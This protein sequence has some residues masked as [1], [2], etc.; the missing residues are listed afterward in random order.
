MEDRVDKLHADF[1]NDSTRCVEL[2]E[3][4]KLLESEV[5]Q[6]TTL[7]NTTGLKVCTTSWC[8]HTCV[9]NK[10][11]TMRMLTKWILLHILHAFLREL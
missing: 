1:S 10:F 8:S 9:K 2:Q 3:E 5:A 6:Q 4:I 11:L 7:K